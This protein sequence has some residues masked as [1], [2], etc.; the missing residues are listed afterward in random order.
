MTRRWTSCAAPAA[1]GFFRSTD[2]ARRGSFSE[3]A[4]LHTKRDWYRL[5]FKCDLTPDHK[6]VAAFEFLMGEPIPRD[7]WAEHSLPIED[8]PLD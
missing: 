5:L 7:D 2:P 6:K 8:K 3:G 1:S 4:A